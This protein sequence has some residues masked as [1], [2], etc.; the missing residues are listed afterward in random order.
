MRGFTLRLHDARHGEEVHDVVSFVGEDDSGS[1]GILAGHARMMTSLVIGLARFRI[2]RQDWRY[3]AMPGAALYFHD[4]VLTLSTRRY[5]VDDDY[6][7]ISAAL[8]EQVLA[9]EQVLHSMKASLRNMEEEVLK[10]LWQIGR[11]A[12][13]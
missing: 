12:P 9:E 8:Q 4:D 5:L 7:R 3:L 13:G 11:G 10:R 6:Q 2:A 1:F